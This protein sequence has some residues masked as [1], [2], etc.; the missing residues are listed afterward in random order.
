MPR[1]G[2]P[3]TGE[4]RKDIMLQIRVDKPTLDSIDECAE[5][6][7]TSRSEIVRKGVELV[8]AQIKK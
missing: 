1:I 8:K 4:A 3:L 6:L 2:R 7:S 5:A